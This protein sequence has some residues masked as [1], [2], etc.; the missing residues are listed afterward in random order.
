VYHGPFST[1][2]AC[3]ADSVA[4]NDPPDIR[5]Y[6]CFYSTDTPPTGVNDPGWYYKAQVST[7]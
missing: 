2:A 3:T 5:D 6:A 1:S 4:K 7:N